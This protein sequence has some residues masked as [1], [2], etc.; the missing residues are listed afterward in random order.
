MPGAVA[1]LHVVYLFS[2]FPATPEWQGSQ[3]LSKLSPP[4]NE[5]VPFRLH[6][7]RAFSHSDSAANLSSGS[8]NIDLQS[9][10]LGLNRLYT[11]PFLIVICTHVCYVSITIWQEEYHLFSYCYVYSRRS[12]NSYDKIFK[13]KDEWLCTRS[14]I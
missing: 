8:L 10:T 5:R 7:A 3:R 2:R 14:H 1:P 11:R 9:R 13:I 4:G 12:E 6:F